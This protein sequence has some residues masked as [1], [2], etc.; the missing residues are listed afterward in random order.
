[1]ARPPAVFHE[2]HGFPGGFFVDVGDHYPGAFRREEDR[3][4]T[5]DPHARAGYQ[6]HLAFKS[7]HEIAMS[8]PFDLAK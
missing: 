2:L 4:F 3:R 7:I 6:G 5:P 1:M 8:F